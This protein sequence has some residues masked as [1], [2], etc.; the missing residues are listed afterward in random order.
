MTKFSFGLKTPYPGTVKPASIITFGS[1][2]IRIN[3]LVIAERVPQSQLP[4][5]LAPDHFE[6]VVAY[7]TET[8]DFQQYIR[9]SMNCWD[10]HPGWGS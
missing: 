8:F 2:V 5:K 7:L 10:E 4:Y 9:K 3:A 6:A 1:N